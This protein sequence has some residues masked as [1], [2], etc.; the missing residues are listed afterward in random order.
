MAADIKEFKHR[1]KQFEIEIMI[2]RKSLILMSSYLGSV[3]SSSN[4]K[5]FL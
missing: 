5:S 2:S 3:S 4:L 1:E